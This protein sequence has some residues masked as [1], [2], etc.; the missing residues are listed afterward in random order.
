MIELQDGCVPTVPAPGAWRKEGE[1]EL[2]R[3]ISWK[4]KQVKV[5]P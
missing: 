3:K 2:E 4:I 1:E 5:W